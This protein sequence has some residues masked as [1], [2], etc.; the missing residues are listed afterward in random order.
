MVHAFPAYGQVPFSK[1]NLSVP[2]KPTPF[3]SN[4]LKRVSINSFGIGGSNAHVSLYSFQLFYSFKLN[5]PRLSLSHILRN[6]RGV[7]PLPTKKALSL[8]LCFYCQPTRNPPS[9]DRSAT[10]KNGQL[11]IPIASPISDLFLQHIVSIYPIEHSLSPSSKGQ[12]RS[13]ICPKSHLVLCL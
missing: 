10:I 12:A 13:R 6:M 4:G 7:Q 11:E 5:F 3:P 1:Y 9:R 8:L 2:L